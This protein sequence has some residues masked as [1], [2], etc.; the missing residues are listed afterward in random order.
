MV[1]RYSIHRAA[2]ILAVVIAAAS[3]T[4]V[5]ASASGDSDPEADTSAAAFRTRIYFGMWTS[6]VRDPGAGLDANSLIGVAF[7]GFYGATFINSY[8]DRAVTAGIQRSFTA[9]KDGRLTTALGYRLGLVT[10]YDERLFGIAGK[11]PVLP[12]VQLVGN[13]DHRKFGMELAYSGLAM[14]VLVNWKL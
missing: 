2:A 13:L 5:S 14:S 1:H 6:H 11:T 7:R 12:L 8:G 10:G 4:P 9:P 3:P